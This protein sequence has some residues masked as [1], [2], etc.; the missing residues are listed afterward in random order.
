MPSKVR[1]YG[2]AQNRTAL[3]I[4]HAYHVMYPNATFEDF[5]KQLEKNYY[6]LLCS[7]AQCKTASES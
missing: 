6:Q 3:G 1:V 4:M 5:Q 2:K 7:F